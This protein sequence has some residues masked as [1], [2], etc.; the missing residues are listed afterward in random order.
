MKTRE[1]MCFVQCKHFRFEISSLKHLSAIGVLAI[2]KSEGYKIQFFRMITIDILQVT[3]IQDY[4]H[5]LE[6]GNFIITVVTVV[7]Q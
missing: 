6:F 3:I 4:L 7:G 2:S 5:L 1:N